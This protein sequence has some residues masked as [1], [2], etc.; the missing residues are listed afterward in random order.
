MAEDGDDQAQ[1][2]DRD[3]RGGDE[4]EPRRADGG[5]ARLV[6]PAPRDPAE[7]PDDRGG[8]QS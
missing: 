8:G 6:G 5:Q 2:R 3:D 7:V 4:K 1:Q